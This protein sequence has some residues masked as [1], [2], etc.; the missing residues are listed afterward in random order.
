MKTNMLKIL[1]VCTV[2]T[3]ALQAKA[4]VTLTVSPS[5]ISNTY[6]GVIT[7]NITGL[8]NTEKVVVQKWQDGNANGVVDAGEL[9]MD[10]FT[11]ADGGAM[12]IGGIT[13]INVPFD[14]NATTGAITTTLNCPPGI[15][16]ENMVG[17]YVFVVSSPTGR[18]APVTAT[19]AITNAVLSQNISGI[20]YSN[21]VPSPY[22]VVVAQ[23]SQANNPTGAAIAD[24]SGHYV[25]ALPPGNYQL[26][27]GAI[28]CYQDQSAGPSFTLTNGI[29]ST[30][31][32]YLTGGG[33]NTI[34]GNVYDAGNSN[35]VGGTLLQFQSGSL[36]E[37]AFTDPNGNYSA[38]VTPAFWKINLSKE[39]LSRSAYV[40]SQTTF[41]VDTTGGSVTNANI[42]LPKGNALFYGRVTDNFNNPIANVE[43]DGSANTTNSGSSNS[44]FGSKGY[45][46]A[47][48]YYTVAVLGDLTNYWNANVSQGQGTAI[49]GYIVNGFQETTN[50]PNQLNLQNFIALAATATISGNVRDNIGTNVSGVT[51]TAGANVGGNNYQSL[52]ATT[53]ANGNYTLAVASG[54]WDVQFLTGG[55]DSDNLDQ[56]GYEDIA[57]PHMVTVPPTNAV[58]NIT[59]YPIG[60]PFIT[61]PQ[62]FANQQ[63]G[64]TINGV[65]NVNY[66]VQVSTNLASTNWSTL[67]SFQLTTNP[68]PVVD[69]HATNGARYYRVQKN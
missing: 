21:G 35:A 30:N 9:L 39:R 13:N 66:T 57:S 10:Q 23:D 48:G 15:P 55:S 36:F 40:V 26:I 22:S 3:L 2:V 38:A 65:T 25:L 63:F 54:Q 68:F 64:F 24:G 32:I 8:T 34:Y 14:S 28:N 27:G 5:V 62:R 16:L 29:N 49:D 46:D 43:V 61:V 44:L 33:P 58:L 1:A 60:T 11:V 51:L 37:V 59:V 67:L 53:D 12:L 20:I 50:A 41:Q 45:S 7:L 19:F 56:Q 69:V 31:N 6:T 47:N 4:V 52:D 17:D 42:A 18:F